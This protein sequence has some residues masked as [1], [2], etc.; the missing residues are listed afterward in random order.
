MG[1]EVLLAPPARG[2]RIAGMVRSGHPSTTGAF[3]WDVHPAKQSLYWPLTWA[4]LAEMK[5]RLKVDGIVPD[6]DDRCDVRR[7][8]RYPRTGT[9]WT[10]ALDLS[11]GAPSDFTWFEKGE[12]V[13]ARS[14]YSIAEGAPDGRLLRGT[15]LRLEAVCDD[16]YGEGMG[17]NFWS[18]PEGG[19]DV[20]LVHSALEGRWGGSAVLADALIVPID[21]PFLGDDDR[22]DRLVRDLQDVVRSFRITAGL[23]M[24]GRHPAPEG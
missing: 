6:K 22:A 8:V 19:I 24:D 16:R 9:L 7:S 13:P 15:V 18:L 21:H 1:P 14:I 4:L 5:K 2:A 11:L 10:P 20:A 3:D 17:T 12:Y 23:P